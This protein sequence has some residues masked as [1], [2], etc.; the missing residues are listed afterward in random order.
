MLYEYFLNCWKLLQSST[1]TI[2][3]KG[4][5]EGLTSVEIGQSAAK[6]LNRK[7]RRRFN[8][9]PVVGS[10]VQVNSKW[11]APYRETE[12]EDIVWTSRESLELRI[13]ARVRCNEPY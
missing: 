11:E 12:G 8:D 10:R 4:V 2:D 5:Y 7:A 6:L 1:T 13:M 3:P 9:Y